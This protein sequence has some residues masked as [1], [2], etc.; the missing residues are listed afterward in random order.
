MTG[1]D[2]RKKLIFLMRESEQPRSPGRPAFGQVTGVR[3]QAPW[4]QDIAC[5]RTGRVSR[6]SSDTERRAILLTR[7]PR[8]S[9]TRVLISAVCHSQCNQSGGG[10]SRRI[11]DPGRAPVLISCVNHWVFRRVGRAGRAIHQAPGMC[12][13]PLRILERTIRFLLCE[14]DFRL[15]YFTRFPR[16]KPKKCSPS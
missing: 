16:E 7:R 8:L 1:A 5:F 15:S 13:A 12:R 10:N 2:R 3:L 9:S 14:C 11:G 4:C 6:L